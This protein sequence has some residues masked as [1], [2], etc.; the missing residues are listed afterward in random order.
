MDRAGASAIDSTVG[1]QAAGQSSARFRLLVGLG[2]LTLVTIALA[3]MTDGNVG[4]IA[5]PTSAVIVVYLLVKVPLRH[6]AAALMLAGLTLENPPELPAA[7]LWR[8]P[9]Y[10]IG[11]IL[12]SQLKG[13]VPGMVMTGSDLV[14]ALLVGVYVYRRVRGS[15]MDTEGAI[16]TPRPLMLAALAYLAGVVLATCWGMIT[17][18][19]F[20][21]V[22]WQ[23][24]RT[25]YMP[26]MFMFIQTAFP[27][28]QYR[29]SLARLI[30]GAAC[31]RAMMAIYVRLKF[32]DAPYGTTH[33]DSMLFATAS[34]IIL[35]LFI[36]KQDRQNMR[37][38][39]TFLPLIFWGML[40][41]N[42]RLAWVEM[43]ETLALV[44][45]FT[46]WTPFKL[47]VLRGVIYAAPFFTVYCIVGWGSGSGL[48]KPVAMIR[49][50]VDS[51]TDSSSAWRDSENFNLAAT[52]ADHP[53]IG[54]GFGHPFG[55]YVPTSEVYELE[56]Y[57]PH[58]S[59]LGLW[60]FTGYVGFSLLWMLL[61]IGVYLAIRTYR[62]ATDPMDRAT[63]LS[64]FSAI[65]IYMLHCYGDMGM[66]TW[67][68]LYLVPVALTVAGKLAVALGAW[69]SGTRQV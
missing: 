38:C 42:R 15:T 63:A 67:A 59:V 60:A 34:C 35:I 11:A 66:G 6:S 16:R 2:F 56:R 33:A 55:L 12:L 40:A 36:E 29:K 1:E 45:A 48:F 27:G 43:A 62:V 58:N 65:V 5:A 54:S 41:N 7:D 3:I 19:D 61:G 39:L 22:L 46:R 23:L 51:K 64:A 14:M 26:L 49:S 13:F 37:R 31:I 8:S 68:S 32:P 4:V 25:T 44:I 52:M 53:L 24:Q 18:G 47:K 9:L 20:K 30:V 28:L 10:P 69:P 21:Y 50:V 17:G 57:V